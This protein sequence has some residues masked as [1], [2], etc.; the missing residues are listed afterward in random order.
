MGSCVEGGCQVRA[1]CGY[2]Q[3]CSNNYCQPGLDAKTC[4]DCSCPIPGVPCS[5]YLSCEDGAH[6]CL[7]NSFYDATDPTTRPENYCVPKCTTDEDCPYGFDCNDIFMVIG[8]CSRGTTCS[9]GQAC[10]VYS[11]ATTGYCPCQSDT[12]CIGTAGGCDE[13]GLCFSHRA[14]GLFTNLQCYDVG[15]VN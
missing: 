5:A 4:A 14:C 7:I 3:R 2:G 15:V 11:E 12:E 8:T 13:N 1:D 6:T 9:N 10:I